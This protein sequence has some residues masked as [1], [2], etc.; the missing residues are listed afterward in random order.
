MLLFMDESQG[1]VS[2]IFVRRLS[3]GYSRVSTAIFSDRP[4]SLI[5]NRDG[6]LSSPPI[7]VCGIAPISR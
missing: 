6:F 1:G 5:L 4:L 3:N 2:Q 7:P